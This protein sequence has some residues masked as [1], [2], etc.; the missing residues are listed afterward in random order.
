MPH[1][2]QHCA[3]PYAKGSGVDG[4]CCAGCQQVYQLIQ[5]EGLD[6]FYRWQDRAAQPLKDR[7][8]A[9]VDTAAWQTAQRE[10]EQGGVVNRAVFNTEGMSC[11]GCAWLIERLCA[12]QAGVERAQVS[13]STHSL[14]LQ[15]RSA[16]FDLVALGSELLRFGYRLDAKHRTGDEVARISPLAWRLL[17][18][19]IFTGNALLLAAYEQ[20]VDSGA[21]R[22]HMASLLSLVCLCF[23]LILGAS[24]FIL[25]AYHAAHI[26]RLHSDWVAVAL[27]VAFGVYAFSHGLSIGAS[28]LSL[29]VLVLIFS[30]WISVNRR[31]IFRS[32]VAT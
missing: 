19:S 13:L 16:E 5:D 14:R 22:G 9:Q 10:V 15:W 20:F 29:L 21:G 1:L 25:S 28:L 31:C 32:G 24:P 6:D 23:T 26:R 7:S 27:I 11:I 3:T 4:F 12:S 30:R 18:T 17:L 8:L 2:C